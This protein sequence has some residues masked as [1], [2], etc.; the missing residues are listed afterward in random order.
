MHSIQ[1][2]QIQAI[3]TYIKQ[4]WFKLTRSQAHLL[5]LAQDSKLAHSVND[6][7]YIYISPREDCQKVHRELREALAEDEIKQVEVRTL[8]IEADLIRQH[9]ILYLPGSY[10]V[11]GGRFNEMYGWDSYFIVLG[12]LRDDELELAKSQVDQLLYEV[13]HYG[14]VLNANRTYMLSRSQP[15]ILTQMVAAVFDRTQDDQWLAEALPLL[16]QFYYY[17]VVPPHLNAG[18]G[19]SRYFALGNGPAPEVLF[20]EQDDAGKSHYDRVQEYY[21]R[22]EVPD[23]DLSLFYDA[24]RGEL[25]DLFYKGD[26]SMRESGFDISNRFGPFSVDIVHYA[27]VCLNSLLYQ[28]ERDLARF[29]DYFGH[30]EIAQQWRDRADLRQTQINRLLWDETCGLYLD[31]HFA[32]ACR[33][34]YAFA[35][36]FYP[37]WLGIATPAQAQRV[38]ENLE[39]FEAPGGLLTSTHV[40]G[41]QWDAPFG[42]APLTLIA[43]QGL[44]RYGYRTEGDRIAAKFLQMVIQEFERTGAIVEKY[45]VERCSSNVSEEICFGYS[46]N[47]VG[48]GWTN[49]VVLELLHAHS[50]LREMG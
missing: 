28:V 50:T 48:F 23:Y 39:L 17:W 8:P 44:Y 15:P 42:W 5:D 3:R 47:E 19:L 41:N 18:T 45:D 20:S 22:F 4:T 12:L 43:V 9:G 26:R 14:T 31:Y 7:W 38:V 35:T 33:R 1:P 34:E 46:S 10:V 13:Q 21:Q 16:E 36:T 29:N 30:G 2:E 32:S 27:P 49:G 24:E 25:T 37:L 11:P 6:R 40:T